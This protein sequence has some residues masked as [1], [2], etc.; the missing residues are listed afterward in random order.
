MVL[1]SV[2]VPQSWEKHPRR[3]FIIGF[4]YSVIGLVLGYFV[5]GKHASIA[6]VFLCS[7]PLVVVMYKALLDEEVKE[8]EPCCEYAI[9]REHTHILMFFIYLFLGVVFSYALCYAFLPPEIIEPLFSMQVSA[10]NSI[11]EATLSGAAVSG[12]GSIS[13]IVS[14]NIVVL[15]FCVVFSFLYGS[16]AIFILILNASAIGVAIGSFVRE[17]IHALAQVGGQNQFLDY[18]VVVPISLTYL[19]HG[20]PEVI[21]YFLGALAGGIISSA[22]VN[23]HVR[24]PRFRQIVLDSLDLIILSLVVLLAAA[25]TE[26]Y[27]TPNLL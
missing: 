16:G 4:F 15:F 12:W 9:M 2:V 13:R 20:I 10:I 3:M 27:I 17:A 14:N 5:F 23:H 11:S 8:M 18:F 6:S 21:S 1:E 26:V 22:V 24:S 7:M 25:Y 19:V